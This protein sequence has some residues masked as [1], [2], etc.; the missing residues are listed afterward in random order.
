[1]I[2]EFLGQS[3]EYPMKV[4]C[5]NV[6]AIY[7]AYYGRISRRTK[8]VDTRTNLIRRYVKDG[9]IKIVFVR[10]E[11]NDAYIFT[12]NTSESTYK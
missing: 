1:M 6:G 2:I 4:V 3:V 10:S 11:E 12:K 9:R 5:D 8:H 7:L